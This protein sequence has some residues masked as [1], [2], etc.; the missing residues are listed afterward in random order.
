MTKSADID[1]IFLMRTAEFYE[2][3]YLDDE[4]HTQVNDAADLMTPLLRASGATIAT[5]S[6]YKL[7]KTA[8]YLDRALRERGVESELHEGAEI[9]RQIEEGRLNPSTSLPELR[10]TLALVRR[11]REMGRIGLSGL[12]IITSEYPVSALRYLQEEEELL[13]AEH[14]GHGGVVLARPGVL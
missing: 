9:T 1:P 10:N 2:Q 12:I 5:G 13:G 7:R 6:V 3:G 11:E 14:I 8:F 4:A